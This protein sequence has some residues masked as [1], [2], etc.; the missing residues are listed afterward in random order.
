MLNPQIDCSVV[1]VRSIKPLDSATI[2]RLARLTGNVVT[3][4]DNVLAGGFGG[5]VLELLTSEPGV[6]VSRIGYPDEFVPQ[7]PI[8]RLWEEYGL[9]ATGIAAAVRELVSGDIA[10]AA[11]KGD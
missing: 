8:E 7:G 1:D 10:V 9:S 3:V 6:A 5:G 4:E 2:L 11:A